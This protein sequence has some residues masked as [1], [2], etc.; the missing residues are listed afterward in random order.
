MTVANIIN[1]AIVCRVNHCA[2]P[3]QLSRK[4]SRIRTTSSPKMLSLLAVLLGAALLSGNNIGMVVPQPHGLTGQPGIF[5]PLFYHVSISDQWSVDPLTFEVFAGNIP[6]AVAITT[7]LNRSLHRFRDQIF[8]YGPAADINSAQCCGPTASNPN[9]TCLRL[10]RLVVN[11]QTSTDILDRC[12]NESYS[13]DIAQTLSGNGESAILNATTVYGATR[14]LMSFS[15]LVQFNLTSATYTVFGTH[16]VDK[17]RFEFRGLLVDTSRNFISVKELQLMCDS[18]EQYKMNI[19]HL[20]LTDIQSWPIEID[21]Y[22]LLTQWLSY[23]NQ[24]FNTPANATYNH[25]YSLDAMDRLVQYCMDRAVRVVPEIDMPGHFP[26]QNAYPSSFAVENS[27][28]GCATNASLVCDRGLIDITTEHGF[29]LVEGI[30]KSIISTFPS[31]EY[32]IGGDEVWSVPWSNSPTVQRLLAGLPNCACPDDPKI[33]CTSIGDIQPYFTRRTVAIIEKLRPGAS[34]VGWNPGIGQ[35]YVHGK[36]SDKYPNFTYSNWYGWDREPEWRDPIAS[37]TDANAENATVVLSGPFYIVEPKWLD[38]RFPNGTE[39]TSHRVHTEYSALQM[40][41]MN[42][43]NF[44]GGNKSKVRGAEIVAWGDAAQ[45]DSGNLVQTTA[46]YIAAMSLQLWSPLGTIPPCTGSDCPGTGDPH[47]LITWSCDGIDYSICT[48]L[49]QQ[50]CLV[51]MRGIP[52]GVQASGFGRQCPVPYEPK[53]AGAWWKSPK[54]L[55]LSSPLHAA[56][57]DT[58]DAAIE[59]LRTQLLS[60]GI[61]P[62]A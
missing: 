3:H 35:F 25:I 33:K 50:R 44:T 54:I 24:K 39:D 40:M 59:L 61:T 1:F 46:I 60:A 48:I 56:H 45:V 2:H 10:R 21:G 15:Q 6:D 8:D 28:P 7:R 38:M 13:I 16:I 58:R 19:M 17:P 9:C 20:H 36:M 23:N 42:I 22:P 32:H 47:T 55:S 5:P 11:I 37:M 31:G 62:E 34:I 49:A 14:G 18:M 43:L 26:A 12:T 29:E 27:P 57:T 53:P 52:G 4:Y 51:L 41:H 30:W